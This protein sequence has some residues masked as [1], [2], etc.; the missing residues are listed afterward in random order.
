MKER[1]K[2]PCAFWVLLTKRSCNAFRIRFPSCNP[3]PFRHFSNVTI[4]SHCKFYLSLVF[5]DFLFDFFEEFVA[6]LF[7]EEEGSQAR[8]AQ[9]W[10][11]R[12]KIKFGRESQVHG[13]NE[14]VMS[15][16]PFL[17]GEQASLF[18]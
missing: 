7:K 3:V 13:Q 15:A 8:S 1:D 4:N 6:S 9:F 14:D 16:L 5:L 10:G 17:C 18:R 2:M 12:S 11:W